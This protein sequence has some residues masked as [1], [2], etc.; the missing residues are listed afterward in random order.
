MK[1]L[2]YF[3][4]KQYGVDP[5]HV[6]SVHLIGEFNKWGN[7]EKKL[8]EFRLTED[9]TG[10]WVGLF[11]VPEKRHFYKFLINRHTVCPTMGLL[12]YSTTSSPEWAKKAVWYQI[13]VDR[14]YRC[15]SSRNIPN[16]ISWDAP[17]D[18]FNN[19]GGG[20][21]GIKEKIGYFK[22]LFG[23]LEN[24]ALY[25][26]PIHKSLASNHKYWPEDFNEIDPQ[27][28]SEKDLKDLIDALHKEKAKIILDLV[29]N[30]TGLNHPAFLD[31]LKNSKKSKYYNWYRQLTHHS[32]G[33]IEVP[34]LEAYVGDK[35]Q[36]IEFEND[37][38]SKDFNPEKESFISVWGGKYK[39]PIIEPDKFS[40]STVEDILNHQPHYKLTPLYN[41]P[42]YKC[43]MNLFEIPELNTKN[44]EVK[45]HLFDSAKHLIRLGIDGFRLDVPDLLE[46][47]HNFWKEFRQEIQEEMVSEG[48]NPDELY[49]VG[50]IWTLEGINSSFVCPDTEGK[51]VRYDALMNYP[52]R[53]SVLNFFSGEILNKGADS[54]CRKGEISI[55]ELDKNIH[56]NISGASWG[57]NQVQFNVFATHDT[58]RMRTVLKDDRKLKAVIM[59]QFTLP[60]A[61]VIYYGEELGMQGGTDPANRATFK[62][63]VYENLMQNKEEAGIFN[64]YKTLIDLRKNYNSL[65]DSPLLT[66]KVDD[67]D[68]VYAYARYKNESDCVI[69]V[70]AKEKLTED[71]NLSLSNLPFQNI[72]SWK[73]PISG[74]NYMN[75]GK[76]IVFK[77]EDF[78]DSLGIVLVPDV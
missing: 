26:N 14:F 24:K 5:V 41:Y 42:S 61:P 18:Y 64:L 16:L 65:V 19:F 20:L 50:E 32:G 68:N 44:P 8:A 34:I 66:V 48:R 76:N 22:N 55:D 63:D 30:H 56:R 38:R 67:F 28:G 4:P 52:I 12:T 21:Q 11:T 13:M 57:T 58:R 7:D 29:F 62:W 1:E 53:E 47:A 49:I 2:F 78:S 40:K 10:R 74:R 71:Y 17:P 31:I 27:F 54:I 70:I 73:D 33:K 43:W 37:P 35:P 6:Q 51:P 45:K 15:D 69:T 23:S 75:Y 77:P 60:G 9:K 39:F 3:H 72:E 46:D 36:N 59:M 25:L